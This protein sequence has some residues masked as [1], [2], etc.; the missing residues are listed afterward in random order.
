MF[1]NFL[2]YILTITA[3]A[4]ILFCLWIASILQ[5]SKNLKFY[6]DISSFDIFLN[7][8][9]NLIKTHYLLLLFLLIVVICI[10][11]MNKAVKNLT[12][13]A[14][15]LKSIKPGDQ[16]LTALLLGT[17]L[18]FCKLFLNDSKDLIYII[19]VA[20]IILVATVI[21]KSSYHF[22]LIVK[23]FLNYRYYEIQTK[24]EVTYFMLSK[25][26]LINS[27]QVNKYV[28]LTDYLLINVT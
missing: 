19:S 22:N 16:N 11:I 4:P 14:I 5:Q 1:S 25:Q 21:N 8:I 12:V 2:K 24:N 7:G 17:I 9:C 6:F 26:K 13:N 27:K 23:L 20:I 10:R 28:Q 15:E 18:P 3:F